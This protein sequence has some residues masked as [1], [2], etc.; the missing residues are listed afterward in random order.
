MLAGLVL[1]R[2]DDGRRGPEALLALLSLAVL[3]AALTSGWSRLVAL[4]IA[5]AG[6]AYAAQLAADDAPLDPAA[7]LVA[8]ALLVVAELAYWSLEERGSVPGDPGQGL[9]RLAF[10]SLVGIC[11]LVVAALLLELVDS[12]HLRGLGVDVAGA[13]AAAATLLVL[14][15]AGRR[16]PGSGA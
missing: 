1:G 10:V 9:R 15:L 12:V 14:L 7:P 6:G 4:G 5:L 2:S 8:A 3:V 16:N 11:A 13:T